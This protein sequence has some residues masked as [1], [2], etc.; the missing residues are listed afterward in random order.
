MM[1]SATVIP[2]LSIGSSAPSKE[3]HDFWDLALLRPP[4]TSA[5]AAAIG[6]QAD[7]RRAWRMAAPAPPQ[8]SGILPS[9]WAHELS[10]RRFPFI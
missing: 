1:S 3:R 2:V 6:G 4:A 9:S 5:I 8:T 7:I 10:G